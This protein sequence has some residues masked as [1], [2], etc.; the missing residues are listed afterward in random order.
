MKAERVV[1]RVAGVAFALVVSPVIGF[2]SAI[3]WFE[4]GGT[5]SGGIAGIV[6]GIAV[7]TLIVW[8]SGALFQRAFD[9]AHARLSEPIAS[10]LLFGAVGALLFGGVML[11]G[12]LLLGHTRPVGW[13]FDRIPHLM[14]LG[15]TVFAVA[16]LAVGFLKRRRLLRLQM[17]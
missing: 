2:V 6:A 4:A 15:F 3:A 14:A 10:C 5:D 16:G 8:K 7:F 17:K 9:T 12:I 13:D 1:T 11:A